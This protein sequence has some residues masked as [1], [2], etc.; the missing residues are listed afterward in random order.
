MCGIAGF[1]KAALPE[2][3]LDLLCRMGKTIA[4]RGP[5]SHGEYVNDYIGLAHRRLSII[6][7]SSDG[8]QPM[9][10]ACGRYSIVFNGEIYNFQELRNKYKAAGYQFRSRTDTE[11]ILAAYSQEGEDCLAQLH[12]MFAFA[13]WDNK[14]K[15]LFLARDRIGKKP[16]YWWHGGGDRL[17]F[18]SEIKPLLEC[19]EVSRQIE[20]T[21]ILDYLKYLYIPAP[22]T[23]FKNIYKLMPGHRLM[24]KIGG[25]P[26]VSQYWD[27]DFSTNDGLSLEDATDQLLHK[28]EEQ[29]A[30]RMVAD[31]PLGAFLSGGVDS[32]GIVGLMAKNST[33]PVKT[34]T[35]GFT[36]KNHD[37]SSYAQEVADRFATDHQHYTVNENLI[38]TVSCLPR[39]FDEPFADSSAVPTYH[40]SRLARKSVT[41][42]L[43]GDGGDESFAGY[44]KY[45]VEQ[46]E[47]RV[48]SYVPS[49]LLQ[50]IHTL[51][52]PA[53]KGVMKKACS[54]AG[55]GL[56]SASDGFYNT[57]TFITDK[58]VR[59]IFS[60]RFYSD[61]QGYDPSEH[62][63]KHWDHLHGAD[64]VSRMLYTDIKTY[65]PGDI[66]V[67][68]DRTS[69]ANSLEVRAPLLDH[70]IIEYA[71]SLPSRWKMNGTQKK[72]ILRKAFSKLLP[73]DFLARKKQGFTVPLSSWFRQDLKQFAFVALFE[74]EFMEEVFNLNML[75]II[76]NQHQAHKVDHGTLLWSLLS[77]SLWHKEYLS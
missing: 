70:S 41:V 43:A 51:T 18:A 6:D 57:N 49:V 13:L 37:E 28:I 22:K 58:Q 60:D 33:Q 59:A 25:E 38:D 75:E 72:Y 55:S 50:L 26:V 16:L 39:Y 54:L 3:D 21:A 67:K 23:I 20:P 46:I 11:V 45:A 32:S 66:L 61:C 40:V 30:L 5:D 47:N 12:G 69:M 17:V 31:V 24:L 1:T 2:G 29:T 10:S 64:H 36:D 68:V 15:S 7:L 77:L 62:T 65:L 4:Y 63:R 71:A 34:C 56:L 73:D 52:S 27:V 42:A 53:E 19:K 8:H 76:W 35:I 14:K 9:H 44:Q 48:R 74:S